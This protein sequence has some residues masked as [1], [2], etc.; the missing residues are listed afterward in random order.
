MAKEQKKDPDTAD[1]PAVTPTPEAS[2]PTVEELAARPGVDAALVA[3]VRARHGWP[4]GLRMSADKFDTA[5]A[6]YATGPT[7]APQ[8]GAQ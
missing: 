4:V 3:G 8:D 5:L 1:T 6:D 2:D 7:L